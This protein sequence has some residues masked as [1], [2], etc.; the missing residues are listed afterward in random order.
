MTTEETAVKITEIEQRCKSNTRRIECLEENNKAVQS[1]ATSVEVMANEQ[2]NI[3]KQLA[4][5]DSKVSALENVPRRRWET[6]VEKVLI[7]IILAAVAFILA[8]VGIA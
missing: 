1:L 7:F 8:K 4:N 3:S 6:V 2:K 5:I